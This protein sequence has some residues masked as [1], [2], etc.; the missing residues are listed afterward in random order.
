MEREFF[1]TMGWEYPYRSEDWPTLGLENLF[2]PS[3]STKPFEGKGT[4]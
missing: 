3:A 4:P 1:S 2:A